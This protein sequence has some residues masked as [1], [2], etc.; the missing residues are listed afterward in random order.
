MVE[1]ASSGSNADRPQFQDGAID[2][3]GDVRFD[4]RVLDVF[5]RDSARARSFDHQRKRAR[6]AVAGR[7]GG[8]SI[9]MHWNSLSEF[10]NMGG[11]GTYVWGSYLVTFVLLTAEIIAVRARQRKLKN[12][13]PARE[14]IETRNSELESVL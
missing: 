3:F 13:A 1:H 4:G 9:I 10:I 6:R 5:N 12:A 14:Q 2:A 11:Y 8:G 7:G